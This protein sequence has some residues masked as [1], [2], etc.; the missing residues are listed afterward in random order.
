MPALVKVLR[1][2]RMDI[3]IVKLALETLGM[4][5]DN[6]NKVLAKII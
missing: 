6:S 4:L 2:D 5:F 3:E 1:N